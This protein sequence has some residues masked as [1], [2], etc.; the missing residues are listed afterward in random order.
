MKHRKKVSAVV[1]AGGF[2]TRLSPMTDT[3]PK[4]LVKILDTTVLENIF[5]TLTDAIIDKICVSTHYQ[6][7]MIERLCREKYPH[8]VCKR[9]CVPLGTAGGVKYCADTESDAVLVVSGDAVF[10]FSLREAID[11]H[12]ENGADV[13]IVT[14]R[15]E[16]PTEYGVVV[17]DDNNNVAEFCEKPSWKNVKSDLVNTGIYVLSKD[18]LFDIPDSIQYDFSKNLFPK[19]MNEGKSIKSFSP[20]GFWCD[21]GT[22]DEYYECN[23][24]AA[25][26]R[27]SCVPNK[28]QR[29]QSLVEK[30]VHA[31][32]GA[33]VSQNTM[34]GKNVHISSG[35]IVCSDTH[36]GDNCDVA[37]SIIGSGTRIGKGCSINQAII[38][39]RSSVGENCI[40][41]EGCIIG[42][43]SRIADGT[44]LEKNERIAAR[45]AVLGRDGT[46][47]LF[48]NNANI[49]VDDGLV[50]FE[51]QQLHT[52]VPRLARAVCASFA[53]G[54]K[55]GV[56]VCVMCKDNCAHIKNA[57]VSGLQSEGANVFDCGNASKAMCACI[58][59]RLCV[60]TGVYIDTSDGKINISIFDANGQKIDDT[61]E[62]KI[63]KA[64]G[65]VSETD[66][67]K[68]M[69]RQMP[70]FSYVPADNMYYAFLWN[71]AKRITGGEDFRRKQVCIT[72]EEKAALCK[73]LCGMS[74]ELV[75][76]STKET[77]NISLSPDGTRAKVRSTNKILD[78]EHICAIVLKNKEIL[79]IEEMYVDENMPTVLRSMAQKD[80]RRIAVRA[81]DFIC[82]NAHL[83]VIALMSA[84]AKRGEEIGALFDEIPLFEIYT[85]EYI[86]K[87]NRGET[88][89]KLSRMYHDSRDDV[90]G[91]IRLSLADGNVTVIPNRAKG[92]KIIS[93]A[94]SMEAAREL[95]IKI[96]DIIK[97]KE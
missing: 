77:I 13:T 39:E 37:G 36:I 75:T 11:F 80:A 43:E 35:S 82:C 6:S 90:G 79:G 97:G 26:G 19:L 62:R 55:S 91:G 41:P 22:F 24:M 76:E 21:I 3:K 74:A 34:I 33:Y 49:F 87:V 7:E 81:E 94:Q 47:L 15:K 64:F 4:P 9:E 63:S 45:S 1:L 54:E 84:A 10:D 67:E 96:G 69:P 73:V 17:T 68:E 31:E 48:S 20:S 27:L 29:T 56:F 25:H 57:F 58:T 38:G 93:E 50:R 44:V 83:A 70:S 18:V 85:D 92:L 30:G 86:G 16:N 32:K 88:V 40:I 53:K 5:C 71:I 66:A 28:G 72:G 61:D 46:R 78:H 12:F 14:C 51:L 2:G 42:D 60:D 23:V 59:S 95:C 8:I 52:F 65:L 89:E